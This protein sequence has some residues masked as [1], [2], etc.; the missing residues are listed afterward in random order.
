MEVMAVLVDTTVVSW[1]MEVP[2]GLPGSLGDLSGLLATHLSSLNGPSLCSISVGLS[3]T[4]I[5][6]LSHIAC[7]R[8]CFELTVVV[9]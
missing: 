7:S 9:S 5:I 6:L 2:S 4:W 8:L 3:Q 1:H